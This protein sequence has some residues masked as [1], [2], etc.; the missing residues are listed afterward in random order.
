MSIGEFIS[1]VVT[2]DDTEESFS[3][4]A[5]YFVMRGDR[6]D[7]HAKIWPLTAQRRVAEQ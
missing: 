1:E 3:T 7:P 2:G 6:L 5:R 4:G